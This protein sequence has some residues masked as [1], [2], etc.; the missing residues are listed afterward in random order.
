MQ[1]TRAKGT[2]TSEGFIPYLDR[3]GL[4]MPVA[5]LAPTGHASVGVWA[6]PLQPDRADDGTLMYVTPSGGRV[7]A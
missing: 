4:S 2:M 5:L 7:K 1:N 3:N 6:S